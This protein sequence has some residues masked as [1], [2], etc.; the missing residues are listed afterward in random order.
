MMTP[1]RYNRG[2]RRPGTRSPARGGRKRADG[3]SK[4]GVCSFSLPSA[5]ADTA[6]VLSLL[7]LVR[8]QVGGA[9]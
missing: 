4:S 5:A 8:W 3:G 7:A 1:R 2:T 9:R 6:V